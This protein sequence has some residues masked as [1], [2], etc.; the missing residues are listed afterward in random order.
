MNTV[1]SNDGTTIAFDRSGGGPPVILVGGALSDRTAAARLA[2]LLAP[3]FTVISYDRRGR[4][5]SGDTPP[6]AVDREIEDLAALIDAAGGDAFVFGHSSGAA[7]ALH[8]AAAGIAIP[9][10]AL[11]EPP[12]SVDDSRVAL[13]ADYGSHLDELIASGRRGD[14]VE[15]FMTVAVAAPPELVAGMRH[16][17]GW[18]AMEAMAHTITYDN[19]VMGDTM[20]GSPAPL[21][22]FAAVQAPTLVMDGGASPAWLQNAA[23]ALAS[24]LPDAQHRTLEGQTHGFDPAVLAPVLVEF[25]GTQAAP[26][27]ADATR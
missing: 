17:P 16:S 6:Y 26:A 11:Y 24:V 25:F 18:P 15:Y 4:G 3:R 1:T 5:D 2:A 7:L 22:R 8:A 13:P 12:F 14:A 23:R 27:T 20:R 19:A 9:R 21:R 10:L